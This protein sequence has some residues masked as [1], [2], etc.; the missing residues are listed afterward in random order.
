[1]VLIHAIAA[2]AAA[3]DATPKGSH[4]LPPIRLTRVTVAPNHHLPVLYRVVPFLLSMA[5]YCRDPAPAAAA[6]V[7]HLFRFHQCS[8]YSNLFLPR[9]RRDS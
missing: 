8:N 9:H 5:I 7:R 3:A 2:A 6:A 4:S 1:M